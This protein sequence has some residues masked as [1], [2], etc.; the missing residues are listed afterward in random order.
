MLA[1][2][3]ASARTQEPA[4]ANASPS[5]PRALRCEPVALDAFVQRRAEALARNHDETLRSASQERLAHALLG[6]LRLGNR[7]CA[8]ETLDAMIARTEAEHRAADAAW[9]VVATFWAW[10]ATADLEART[11]DW[12]RVER[13][14]RTVLASR[15]TDLREAAL[16]A[17]A[18][19]C[20]AELAAD[21]RASGY[22]QHARSALLEFESRHWSEEHGAFVDL[23]SPPSRHGLHPCA[24]GM[25]A[26]TGDRA[27]RNARRC[28][29]G[30]DGAPSLDTL[31]AKAQFESVDGRDLA[32]RVVSDAGD[33]PGRELDAVLFALTGLRLATGP[34]VDAQWLRLRPRLPAGFDRMRIDGLASDGYAIAFTFERSAQVGPQPVAGATQPHRG[35]F[36]VTQQGG[37]ASWR[38]LVVHM[39]GN[40]FVVAAIADEPVSLPP[41]AED[42]GRER[43][44]PRD[45]T[46]RR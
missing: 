19:A 31:V 24:I 23:G 28:L 41:D 42:R 22:V 13:A 5:Q 27:E 35:S 45:A 4:P 26:A 16:R 18:I 34:G 33:E 2:P 25:L 30:N 44:A 11:S 20:A 32:A 21:D 38:Q 39:D 29:S 3:M 43:P 1:G 6:W 10:R 7:L 46:T 36:T 9:A 40:T 12:S 15:P 37:S 17:H 14:V 8:Q